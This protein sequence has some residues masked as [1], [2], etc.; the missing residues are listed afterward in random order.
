MKKSTVSWLVFL[1]IWGLLLGFAGLSQADQTNLV[2]TVW[3]AET[4]LPVPDMN[5]V[6]ENDTH[7]FAAVTDED[8]AYEFIGIPQGTYSIYVDAPE[9]YRLERQFAVGNASASVDIAAIPLGIFE[10]T[11]N[12]LV[13][14]DTPK[15]FVGTWKGSWR[16]NG[17][18]SGAIT[19]RLTSR[20]SKL[21]GTLTVTRTDC[22]TASG[23]FTGSYSSG[24]NRISG[25]ATDRCG[26]SNVRVNVK[27]TK[28]G[29]AVNGTYTTIVD[30]RFYDS[31][32][33]TLTKR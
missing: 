22:G 8:G 7:T 32:T 10:A 15:A 12:D 3:H 24:T 17:S 31:G 28:S 27:C 30:G 18:G 1:V 20:G 16:S 5:V 25:H 14:V 19:L 21:K 13:S 26:G 23:P 11:A 9:Y 6:V 33:C 2:G 4:M 29:N